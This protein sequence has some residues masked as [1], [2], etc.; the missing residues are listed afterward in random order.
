MKSTMISQV[1]VE[2]GQASSLPARHSFNSSARRAGRSLLMT[3]ILALLLIPAVQIKSKAQA[4][5]PEYVPLNSDQLDQLV[6]PIALDPDPLVAQILIGCTFPDQVGDANNWLTTKVNFT[7]DQIATQANSM[8]WDPSIKGLIIFP[9][10]LDSMAKNSAWT[11]QLGNA[12]YNQPDDVMDA[13]QAMRALAYKSQTLVATAQQNVVVDAELIE[14][15]PTNPDVV[16]VQFYNPWTVFGT[17]VVAYP[18]FV[19]EPVP[20]GVVVVGGVAF[21]PAVSVGLDLHFGFSF[22]GWGPGWGGG[23]VVYN[24]NVYNSN[25]RTVANRGHFGGHDGRGFGRDGRGFGHDGRGFDRGG[26]SMNAGYHRG[27]G[28]GPDRRSPMG[29][30]TPRGNSNPRTTPVS[31]STSTGRNN[32]MNHTNGRTTSNARTNSTGRSTSTGRATTPSHSA[33]TGRS[34]GG[35]RG[36]G[37]SAP[38]AHSQASSRSISQNRPNTSSSPSANRSN[39]AG[40]SVPASQ[41]TSRPGGAN[42]SLGANRSTSR[43]A[44]STSGNQA[45]NRPAAANRPAGNTQAMN[46]PASMGKSGGSGSG[47]PHMGGGGGKK[48]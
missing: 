2:A 48:R 31:R 39:S 6:A 19:V 44:S 18:G 40:R 37:Q 16:F 15:V 47:A 23:A 35:S 9:V 3:A 34:T 33:S 27:P 42:N 20:A 13:I 10:V 28:A 29:R 4:I 1:T 22:G 36:T 43:P 7:P 46:H 38:A 21:E 5:V 25:S 45:M 32:S 41:S 26:R 24:N 12:Y 14:I 11:T 30:Q 8:N 17:A